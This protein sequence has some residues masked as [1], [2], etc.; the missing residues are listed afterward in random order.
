MEPFLAIGELLQAKG[1]EVICGLPEQFRNLAT[2]SDL[3]FAS[4]G[5]KFSALLESADG[6]A[7]MGG[8]SGWRKLAGT[9]R[10][11]FHQTEA[12]KEVLFKQREI[13]V[14]NKPDCVL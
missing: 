5:G 1:H 10:L 6:K 8:A 3:E 9:I 13:I 2:Q 11:A 14:R 4:L 7:A 12:N